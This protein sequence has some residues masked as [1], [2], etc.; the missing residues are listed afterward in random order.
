[1]D[2]DDLTTTTPDERCD[3]ANFRDERARSG[4]ESTGIEIEDGIDQSLLYR[5]LIIPNQLQQTQRA[6]VTRVSRNPTMSVRAQMRIESQRTIS[7]QSN[8]FHGPLMLKGSKE[9]E[10]IHF[11]VPLQSMAAPWSTTTKTRPRRNRAKM[12][13]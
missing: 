11:A 2:D 5:S 6:F 13:D 3:A 12:Y 10:R 4:L 1:V 9:N 7:H 8:L